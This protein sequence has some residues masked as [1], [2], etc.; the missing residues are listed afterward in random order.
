[1]KYTRGRHDKNPLT[2]RY[3]TKCGIFRVVLFFKLPHFLSYR[4]GEISLSAARL[5][6][7]W[8]VS[9]RDQR[10]PRLFL[11]C[12]SLGNDPRNDPPEI[13]NAYNVDPRAFTA[14]RIQFHQAPKKRT[15]QKNDAN[16][17]SFKSG[18]TWRSDTGY[19]ALPATGRQLA[20]IRSAG[21]VKKDRRDAAETPR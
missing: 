8:Q 13:V 14:S 2:R 19:L 11:P 4:I 15:G 17:L 5:H 18:D 10:L 3:R 1:M 20:R 16:F 6:L 7:T 12:E 9:R 21:E